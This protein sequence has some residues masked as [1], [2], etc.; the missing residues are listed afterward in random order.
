MEHSELSSSYIASEYK[1]KANI[2]WP[3]T[4]ILIRY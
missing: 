2:I 1:S 4:E 3:L